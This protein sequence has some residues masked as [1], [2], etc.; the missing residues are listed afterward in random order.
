MRIFII[1]FASVTIACSSQTVRTVADEARQPAQFLGSGDAGA[2]LVYSVVA[3]PYLLLRSLDIAKTATERAR[4]CRDLLHQLSE[5]GG[6]AYEWT[7]YF[8]RC[9]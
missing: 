3:V 5:G 6:V 8:V 7:T 4:V 9:Q 2:A 1:I